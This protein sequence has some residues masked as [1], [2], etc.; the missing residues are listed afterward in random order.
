MAPVPV[1]PSY[2]SPWRALRCA[3]RIT[4]GVH[5]SVYPDIGVGCCVG[6]TTM[7][8]ESKRDRR[9][10]PRYTPQEAAHHLS[11]PPATGESIATDFGMKK[12]RIEQ[13]LRWEQRAPSAA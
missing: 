6:G 5:S 9:D 10:V 8:Q 4:V 13:A 1:S 12:D 2:L 11:M 3:I 7:V